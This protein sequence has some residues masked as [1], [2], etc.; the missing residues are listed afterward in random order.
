MTEMEQFKADGE[1]TRQRVLEA[2]EEVFAEKG[3]EAASV[4]DILRRADVKNIAAINYHFGD[5]DSL[6]IAAVKHAHQSCCVQAFP[7]WPEGTA[8]A[9]K[10]RD[11]VRT[12]V[13]RMLEPGRP[14][15]LRLMMREMAQPTEACAE[16]VRDYIRPIAGV[17]EGI[18][19][20][21]RPDLPPQRGFLVGNSIVAQCLFYRQNRPI[22]EQ[23]MGPEMFGQLSAEVLTDHITSFSLQALGVES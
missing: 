4:R 15:A 10:L 6:Y 9:V 21:L 18:L 2:A 7:Q 19:T 5:K 12:M 3:R 22:I 13:E 17:L 8:P 14:S 20:E 16:V 23:L 1:A 11:F